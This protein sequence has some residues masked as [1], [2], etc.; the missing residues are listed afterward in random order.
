MQA[1]AIMT[2]AKN[3]ADA[4]TFIDWTVT[5]PAMETYAARYSVVAMPVKIKKRE[6]FP[7]RGPGSDDQQRLRMGGEQQEPN[8]RRVATAVR[9]QDRAEEVNPHHGAGEEGEA[10]SIP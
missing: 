8:R 6:H 1:V 2:G 3:L 10:E 5:G 7:P 4:R 9:R